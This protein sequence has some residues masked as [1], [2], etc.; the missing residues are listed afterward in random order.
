MLTLPRRV[1]AKRSTR[2]MQRVS[3]TELSP[4]LL[5]IGLGGSIALGEQSHGDGAT[6]LAKD[7][8]IRFLHQRMVKPELRREKRQ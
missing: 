8:L 1:E 7:R 3:S 4:A 6:F 2:P 5:G